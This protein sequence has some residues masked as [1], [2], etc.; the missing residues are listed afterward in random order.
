[1]YFELA[2]TGALW[3]EMAQHG[4]LALH[5]SGDLPSLKLELWG[6]RA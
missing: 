4:G 2:R 3:E 6:I 1:V 5:V